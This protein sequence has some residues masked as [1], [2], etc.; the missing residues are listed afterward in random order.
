MKKSTQD[1]LLLL[2]LLLKEDADPFPLV[3]LSLSVAST[4]SKSV[5]ETSLTVGYR[6]SGVC[7]ISPFC[8]SFF[9]FGTGPSVLLFK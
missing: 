9:G 1:L 7:L 3:S 5:L 2:L 8:I 6:I 4:F